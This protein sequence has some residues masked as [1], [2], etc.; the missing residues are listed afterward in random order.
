MHKK[1]VF[2]LICTLLI[3]SPPVLADQK[4]EE[5]LDAVIKVKASIPQDASTARVL[6]TER[7]GNG[8]VIDDKG[9][10]LTIGYLILEAEA[11]E[12]IGAQGDP[13][14]ARFVAYDYKTG[15]RPWRLNR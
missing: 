8:V 10:I 7:E 13:V 9:H 6:G 12:V 1:Y 11:I 3:F 2:I 5:V 14:K 15:F 4:P